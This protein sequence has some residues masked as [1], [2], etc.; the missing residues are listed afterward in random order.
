MVKFINGRSYSYTPSDKAFDGASTIEL[1]G[2][3]TLVW[4]KEVVQ[5]Y[6]VEEAFPLFSAPLAMGGQVISGMAPSVRSCLVSLGW[7]EV[8]A[9]QFC[10][11]LLWTILG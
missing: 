5:V 3:Y 10:T 9:R 4:D 1:G 7:D 2:D 6:S 8:F 11:E